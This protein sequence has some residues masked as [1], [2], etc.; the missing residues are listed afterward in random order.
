MC[1][2]GGRDV[3]RVVSFQN[4]S[5]AQLCADRYHEELESED[6]TKCGH[7]ALTTYSSDCSRRAVGLLRPRGRQMG[8]K[9]LARENVHI[10]IAIEN[11]RR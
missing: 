10:N 7:R 1:A 6:Q 9:D 2:R 11:T 4:M 3:R 8:I 5:Y